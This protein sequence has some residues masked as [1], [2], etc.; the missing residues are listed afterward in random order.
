MEHLACDVLVIGSGAAGL[1][2]AIAARSMD[3][4]VTVLS[5]GTPG[6]GTCTVLSGGVFAATPP[7]EPV[8]THL[9][10][11]LNAGRGINQVELASALVEDGPRRLQELVK[12]G[13]KGSL[14]NGS[15][16]SEGRPFIWGEEIINCLGYL[17]KQ[18]EALNPEIIV[19]LGAHAARTLLETN[20]PIGQLRGRFHDYYPSLSSKPIKMMP[21]YH[22]AYLLRNYSHDNRMRV[23][24]DMKKVLN[25]L[26][27]KL[28][29]NSK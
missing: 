12:W 14:R 1:R 23:W 3:C 19:A 4:D 2:A 25:E 15:L 8:E 29:E 21:T 26:G 6:K 24:E 13:I 22:P 9:N 18:L 16:I 17:S 7:G 27:L 28:P 5:K 10:Q 20:R 11:T